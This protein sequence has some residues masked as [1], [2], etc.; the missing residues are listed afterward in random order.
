MRVHY[1]DPNDAEGSKDQIAR[2]IRT[3]LREIDLRKGLKVQQ[4][5]ES[6]DG[7]CLKLLTDHGSFEGFSV[8]D[9]LTMRDA[10]NALPTRSAVSRMLDRGGIRTDA[11]RQ[12][13][14][15]AYHWTLLGQAVL[16][17]LGFRA[18]VPTEACGTER[19][20]G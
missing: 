18:C 17:R 14:Q 19:R 10:M 12:A 7:D 4:A 1:Y 16:G 9:P 8:S 6:L 15:C 20:D 3:C 2:L 13:G 11:N 5:A